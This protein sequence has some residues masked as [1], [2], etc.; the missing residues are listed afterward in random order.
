MICTH[1]KVL[2]LISL[3]KVFFTSL[4]EWE[5]V[6]ICI[7]PDVTDD[8]DVGWAA[9]VRF[10]GTMSLCLVL[11]LGK[12]I[13][14]GHQLLALMNALLNIQN[15][16][17]ISISHLRNEDRNFDLGGRLDLS[18]TLCADVL[19]VGGFWPKSYAAG[20]RMSSSDWLTFLFSA[21]CRG[22]FYCLLH[23]HL[24][25]SF[26]RWILESSWTCLDWRKPLA[27]CL[28]N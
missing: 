27:L 3:I 12:R 6:M 2:L 23:P 19:T 11:I 26:H 9:K 25:R 21:D 16:S 5:S 13:C 20:I 1:F 28:R 18:L 4:T 15:S 14:Q 24:F 8:S 10:E 7:T 17:W 22:L